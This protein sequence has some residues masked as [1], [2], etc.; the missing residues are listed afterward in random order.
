MG[1]TRALARWWLTGNLKINQDNLEK[2]QVAIY[3]AGAAGIQI[4][5]GLSGSPDFNPVAFVDDSL[6]LQGNYIHG[7]RVYSF[8]KLSRHH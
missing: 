6:S 2:K 3:G 4:A 7:L 5:A 1:G 8:S